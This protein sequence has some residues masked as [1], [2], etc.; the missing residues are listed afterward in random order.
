MEQVRSKYFSDQSLCDIYRIPALGIDQLPNA[1]IGTTYRQSKR[2]SF[3][4]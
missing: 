3:Q 1:T 2:H 4:I